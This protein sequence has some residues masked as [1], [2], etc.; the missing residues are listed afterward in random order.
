MERG[1]MP[2]GFAMALAQNPKAM[3]K[4]ARLTEAEKQN[5]IAGTHFVNSREEMQKYVNKLTTD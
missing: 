2:V 1:E 4:F 3:E 5:I